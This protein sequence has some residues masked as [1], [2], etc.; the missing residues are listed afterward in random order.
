MQ[1][2]A[3]VT[4]IKRQT[5]KRTGAEWAKV[6]LEDF[7]GSAE[8]L[9]FPEAWKKLHRVLLP[10]GAFL[11]S[12]GYS[13]RDRGEEDAPFI[14]EDA[15]P[16][17]DFRTNGRVALALRWAR[18]DAM[19]AGAMQAAAAVCRAHPGRAPV[20]VEW[21]DDNGGGTSRFRSKGLQVALD[22]DLISA[23]KDVVG[24]DK[25]ELVRAG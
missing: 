21:S 4:S 5:A 9:V 8:A 13:L 3:V 7:H 12:G 14:V 15:Q 20:L 23:L 25:V 18:R 17:A 19:P 6:T 22:D 16:L 2:A 1:V 11:V 10:D 24:A